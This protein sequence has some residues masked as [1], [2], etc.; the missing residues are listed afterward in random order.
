MTIDDILDNIRSLACSQGFYGRLY[1]TLMDIRDTEPEG[2]CSVVAELES[3]HFHD[4][5]DMVL[6]FEA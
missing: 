6:Y 1:R 3:Q 5:V 2:W 4:A